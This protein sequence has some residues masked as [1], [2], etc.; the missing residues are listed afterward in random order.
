[1][2]HIPAAP[3]RRQPI[4]VLV[5][6]AVCG[7][8]ALSSCSSPSPKPAGTASAPKQGGE[9]TFARLSSEITTL[10]PHAPSSITINAYTL[11]KIFDTLYALDASGTPEPS[12]AES[13]EI[14]DD[15]L[16]WTFTLR[17]GVKF[18]DGSE[19]DAEDVVY[20]INRHLELG[21]YVPLTAPIA[22]VKAEG[23]LTVG[24][25]LETPY[26]PLLSELSIFSSSIL[27][28]DLGGKP[29]ET[30]FENPVGTGPFKVGKWDKASGE[31]DLVRNDN[32]WVEG[33][34]YLDTVHLTTVEDD[35]QLVQQV[36]SGQTEIVDDVP[37][38]NVAE[39]ESSNDVEVFQVG[40]WNQDI[41]FFNNA[42]PAF[43]DRALRRAVAQAVDREALTSATTF[44]TGTA[45]TTFI[46]NAIRYSDQSAAA[47]TY[48]VDK[49][50]TELAA[51]DHATGTKVSLTVEGGSQSRAQQAQIIQSSL[52]EIGVEVEIE[53]VDNA[54]FWQR[55][56]A[57]Q[58]DFALSTIIADTAD[59]D[60]ICTWQVYGKGA[61]RSFYTSYNNDDVNRLVEQGRAEPDGDKRAQI[62]SDIQKLVSEDAPSLP[63]DYVSEIK[64]VRGEVKGLELIPNGT[65]RLERVWIDR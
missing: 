32:Y 60:N 16:T 35:N 64:A 36:L 11:D 18:S 44:G 29:E 8:L 41:V 39:L 15:G 9:I 23:P 38:A 21:G 56:P 59:P 22:G 49:A 26:T 19:L 6:A 37:I 12:L 47:L 62:Y 5:A 7:A 4:P 48:D 27:P 31:F 17:E 20:S 25:E 30:F 33:L 52:A 65:V 34:P 53:T 2:Q 10:D 43:S 45:A 14:T 63:L 57:G 51:S 40:S 61:T 46:P 1:M 24:I 58:Y 55:F 3:V 42:S 50:R 13:H 54:T 28:A